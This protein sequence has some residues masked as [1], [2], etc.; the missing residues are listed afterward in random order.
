[1]TVA[2]PPNKARLAMCMVQGWEGESSGATCADLA[3][4]GRGRGVELLLTARSSVWGLL[5]APTSTA[6]SM[7]TPVQMQLAQDCR[8]IL[9]PLP[10]LPRE[11]PSY[12]F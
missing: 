2:L 1:M 8:S 9:K 6:L 3:S 4:E 5:R 11:G 12:P 10:A 7:E